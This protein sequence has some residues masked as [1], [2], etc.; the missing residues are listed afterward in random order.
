MPSRLAA[1]W[2][3]VRES[4]AEAM[5]AAAITPVVNPQARRVRC[6]ADAFAANG[7]PAAAGA[8]AG[9]AGADDDAGGQRQG[10]EGDRDAHE[11]AVGAGGV[12]DVDGGPT[13]PRELRRAANPTPQVEG[14]DEGAHEQPQQGAKPDPSFGDQRDGSPP[15]REQADE[16]RDAAQGEGDRQAFESTH[17]NLQ[18]Q[19][20]VVPSTEDRRP[21]SA[22]TLEPVELAVGDEL[23]AATRGRLRSSRGRLRRC[24][25]RP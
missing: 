16:G 1:V 9:Q 6:V 12:E 13:P 5:Q 10:G 21:V 11:E 8:G 25:R 20:P 18:E 24:R 3:S 4:A 23:H 22:I 15:A 7:A 14:I 2:G 19:W 17:G